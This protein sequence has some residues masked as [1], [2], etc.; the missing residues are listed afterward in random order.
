MPGSDG[1]ISANFRIVVQLPIF[2]KNT[3]ML[4]AIAKL[5]LDK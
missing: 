5:I 1:I 4:A 2:L 3:K